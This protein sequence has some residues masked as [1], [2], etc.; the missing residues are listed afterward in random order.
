[1]SSIR[2]DVPSAPFVWARNI[3]LLCCSMGLGLQTVSAQQDHRTWRDYGGGPDNSKFVAFDQINKSNV[4]KL[5]P[6]WSY[7]TRDANSYSFNP[8]IIG[9]VM[10]VLARGSSLVAL[11]AT[12]GREMWVH[13]NLPGMAY[14][15]INYWESVNHKDRRLIFQIN[16]YV[17][18]LNADT[19]KSIL[20][21]G[22][23][24][25]VDLRVGLGRDLGTIPRIKN[26]TPGK[27]FGNVVILGSSTGENYLAPPGDIRAYDVISGK[28]VWTFHTVPHPGEPGYET[29][30]KD[31]WKYAGGTNVWGEIT[32]DPK[33]GIVYA[34]TGSPT[35]DLYGADRI[36][37]DL[38]ADCLLAIDARTGKLLWHFQDVHHDLWD[39]DLAAA[40]Q[41]ITIH[42]NGKEIEAVAQA[43]KNGF[44]YVFD[45]NTGKPVWPIQER[46]VPKSDVPGE[47][48]SPTQPFPTAPPPFAM[49]KFNVADLDPYLMSDQ[50]RAEWK[51]RLE[52]TNNQGL[53]TPPS[54]TKE[55]VEMPGAY[56]GANWGATASNP[57]KGLVYVM[58]D[59]L[60]SI[61]PRVS[62]K[63]FGGG[64]GGR[65]GTSGSA[66][67]QNNCAACH[68]SDHEGT[69]RAPSLVG[70]ESQRD[71][72]N[73]KQFVG[74]GRGDMPAFPGLDSAQ[75][76]RL[77]SFLTG[78]LEGN[79]SVYSAYGP[80]QK[81]G[82]PVVGSG[83]APGGL[84]RF[85]TKDP[86]GL[87]YPEGVD[88]P[89][90][91][92]SDYG[93]NYPQIVRPPWS[94][95]A[96]YD[97][98]T[99]TLQWNIP[100]GEEPEATK[101]AGK[102][103]GLVHGA[104]HRGI[105]VTSTGLLFVNC[106]DS[107]LRAFDAETGKIVWSYQLPTGTEGIPAMYEVDGRE[108]LVVGATARGSSSRMSY[109][110]TLTR[111][112]PELAKRAYIVFALPK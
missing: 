78:Q 18:E 87:P 12:T 98:N 27:V 76:Q 57:P 9:K 100:L 28:M 52:A 89:A 94:G 35:Y 85:A 75:L 106:A 23:Q 68:G 1:M 73:F 29:W 104:N 79:G 110:D 88:A 3:V 21:F 101:K 58:Y 103:T 32:L 112:D 20:T 45:R 2:L 66:I 61:V 53:F 93:M 17:E 59:N 111:Q 42:H 99:G 8:I 95:L 4:G 77:Y 74:A 19:G 90:R 67:Y 107:K 80:T 50:E 69:G 30:P 16:Y 63:P 109:R 84:L 11:D 39:Y 55:S 82:G 64:G 22:N 62:V 102:D 108:Y 34:P 31:A 13:E 83:G 15:G 36:G 81:L 46:P 96:A 72:D 37:N 105:I 7:P 92:Y 54:A 14:R 56:G 48:A 71:L 6:V 44:L 43:G 38:Y 91:M 65:G 97:L 41:L 86:G 47:I 60:P 51:T 10:Y 24:G 5:A 25:L 49:Q 70:I 26:D 40:P 33:T